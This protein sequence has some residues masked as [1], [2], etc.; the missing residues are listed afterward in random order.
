[1][2]LLVENCPRCGARQHTFD[3]LASVPDTCSRMDERSEIFSRCRECKKA[4]IFVIGLRKPVR[5]GTV[6]PVMTQANLNHTFT[7]TDFINQSHVGAESPPSHLP[8]A[9]RT[10]FEEAA[11]AFAIGCWNAAGCMFRVSIDLATKEIHS[12]KG[13]PDRLPLSRRLSWLFDNGHI[14]SD[15]R[16]LA[17]CINDDGNDAA[18]IAGLNK[19]DAEDLLDFSRELLRR[20]Y[21]EPVRVK[22]A[23]ERRKRR[24]D[25]A[26]QGAD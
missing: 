25:K 9:V 26:K 5:P 17:T 20:I 15:L 10:A 2:S 19:E 4:T 22:M 1:M 3:V 21:T 7:V 12:A 24:R 14:P 16:D 8:D 11:R 18:H 6:V 13:G 23:N